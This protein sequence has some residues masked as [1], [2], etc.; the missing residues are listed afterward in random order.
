MNK[1]TLAYLSLSLL[2]V[3]TSLYLNGY[4]LSPQSIY[5]EHALTYMSDDYKVLYENDELAIVEFQGITEIIEFDRTMFLY[6]DA[7]AQYA[8]DTLTLNAYRFI[9]HIRHSKRDP[10]TVINYHLSKDNDETKNREIAYTYVYNET[11]KDVSL[12]LWDPTSDTFSSVQFEEIILNDSSKLLYSDE[13]ISHN[14]KLIPY[15]ND[16]RFFENID[17]S[18]IVSARYKDEALSD[19]LVKEIISLPYTYD[20]SISKEDI[21][22]LNPIISIEDSYNSQELDETFTHSY[23][24]YQFNEEVYLEFNDSLYTVS[25]SLF[26]QIIE[27]ME[28]TSQ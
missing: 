2:L 5:E 15:V 13:I 3:I 21:K 25:K 4:R 23:K 10:I 7:M 26:D 8:P 11:K 14:S 9:N 20:D 22:S 19:S 27:K 12:K 17:T 1:K 16:E 28:L 24:F 18:G 6:K